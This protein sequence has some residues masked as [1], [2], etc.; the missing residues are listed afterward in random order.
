MGGCKGRGSDM[1][2]KTIS[3]IGTKCFETGS[4]GSA[5]I[6]CAS[7]TSFGYKKE[8]NG[9]V[10]CIVVTSMMIIFSSFLL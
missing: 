7:Y 10:G 9:V 8:A 1:E 3:K 2:P 6:E 5:K 4:G